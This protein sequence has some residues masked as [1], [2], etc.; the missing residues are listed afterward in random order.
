MRTCPVRL[1][2]RL[3]RISAPTIVEGTD[4][5]RSLTVSRPPHRVTESP[6]SSSRRITLEEQCH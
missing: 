6:A 1:V 4:E 5:K 3:G 2:A